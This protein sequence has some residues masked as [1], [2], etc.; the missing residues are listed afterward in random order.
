MCAANCVI[1]NTDMHRKNWYIYRDTGRSDEWA[2]LPWDLDLAHGRKWNGS[3]AYFD[4]N[5]FSTGVIQVGTSV[6]LVSLL[7]NRTETRDMLM[8]RIR[9]LSDQYLQ[10]A[11][12]PYA[13]RYLERRLDEQSALIDPPEISPSD[14]RADFIKWG[15][16]V[17]S[18]GSSVSYTSSHPDVEDMA[19]GIGRWK[20]EYLPG[21]RAY[22]Y[23]A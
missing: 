23:G 5:L 11:D 20:N 13:E 18:N 15:S 12:T 19:E 8:R 21:R 14:A 4:N 9:T 6:K 7:W 22:M 10:P 2:I 3:D 16:W 17:Q 1:R